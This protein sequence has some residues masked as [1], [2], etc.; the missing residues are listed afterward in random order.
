LLVNRGA[1]VTLTVNGA[2]P[3]GA[4]LD[5]WIDFNH[6][7]KF[8]TDPNLHEQIATSN[9]VFN[10]PN[11]IS[12]NVPS[13]AIAGGTFARFRLS[14]AGGL[15]PTGLAADGEVED[16]G[17]T[18][19]SPAGTIQVIPNPE[20]PGQNMLSITGTANADTIT[21]NQLRTPKLQVQVVFN[22]HVSS[23]INI[24]TFRSIVVYAGAGNDTVH[25]N[26]AMP[27]QIHGE[28]GADSLY[29]GGGNDE[30]Y[31][32]DGNDYLSGGSGN[33]ILIGGAGNDTLLGGAGR[34]VLIG[35]T[36]VDSLSDNSGDNILIGGSTDLDSNHA[37]L[38]A[39]MATW[40]NTIDSF[41]TR[42]S[43]LGPL[44][45]PA[46]VHDDNARDT[47]NGGFGHTGHDWYLDYLAKDL[48]QNFIAS[49]DKKN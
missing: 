25:I 20:N 16:Y 39:V 29:G 44:I 3:T 11:T 46:T 9:L 36:G 1:V 48:I 43:K 24:A 7:G 45:N 49:R 38:Q 23:P 17:V 30:I 5:A 33:D 22:G 47:L 21:V 41:Q 10:G 26:V 14:S 40:G 19:V 27:A 18:N 34:D 13:T 6:N 12:F 15:G 35:G 8:D 37:A 32:D 4:K 31:G 28:A 42:M 2:P